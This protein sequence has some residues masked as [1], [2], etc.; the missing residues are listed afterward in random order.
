MTF[1]RTLHS[2]EDEDNLR[3]F[4]N[5]KYIAFQIT[6]CYYDQNLLYILNTNYRHSDN[7]ITKILGLNGIVLQESLENKLITTEILTKNCIFTTSDQNPNPLTN[8]G[9]QTG[10]RVKGRTLQVK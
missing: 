9:M 5:H 8:E 10:I 2:Q 6:L 4:S 3:D 7:E 1:Q